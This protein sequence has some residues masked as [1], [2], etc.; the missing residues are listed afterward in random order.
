TEQE[1]R[2]AEE[3][4]GLA[5]PED[6][7]E[8]YR[9]HNGTNHAGFFPAGLR[10]VLLSLHD[11]VRAW[12]MWKRFVERDTLGGRRPED[13]AKGVRRDSLNVGW[14]PFHSNGGGDYD[15]GALAPAPGG[16]AGQ[17]I[18]MNHETGE[19]RLIAPSLRHWLHN[20]AHDLE[21]G[22]YRFEDGGLV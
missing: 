9:A 22:T 14:V 6:V 11:M 16:T 4:M 19:H 10:G 17:I 2:E 12:R 5:L 1:I 3:A 13:V 18:T 7:R 15:C 20:F 21:D 8:S